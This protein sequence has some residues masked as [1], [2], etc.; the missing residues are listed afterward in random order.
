LREKE[1]NP[2]ELKGLHKNEINRIKSI[3]ACINTTVVIT[4]KI[5][6]TAREI[7]Y[8]K[9]YYLYFLGVTGL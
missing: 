5:I 9:K 1:E 7:L 2:I 8:D 4:I 6:P 3:C